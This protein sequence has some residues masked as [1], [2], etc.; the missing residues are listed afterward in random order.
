[1]QANC[2]R[3]VESYA[4]CQKVKPSKAGPQDLVQAKVHLEPWEVVVMDL[5]GPFLPTTNQFKYLCVA[6]DNSTKFIVV[7]PLHV[8]D[9]K[10]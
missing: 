1:M 7:K 2:V 3:F 10:R 9:G 5:Q 8:A 4:E 6:M